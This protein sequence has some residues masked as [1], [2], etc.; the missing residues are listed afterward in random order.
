[1]RTQTIAAEQRS[2]DARGTDAASQRWWILAAC[3]VVGFAQLAEPQLWMIGFN[4]PASAFGTA[5]RGY[6]VFA[7]LGVVLFIA[8]Q[9]VGGVL[10]DL[11]GRRRVLL[12]GAAGATLSNALSLITWNIES[13]VATR[14]LVGVMGALAF[15]L[16]LAVVRLVFVGRERPLALLIYTFVTAVGTLASLLAIPIDDWFGWRWALLLPIASGAA[17]VALAWR[18]LPESRAA[19]GVRRVE[20]ITVAAWT[21]VLLALSFGLAVAQTSGTLINPITLASAAASGLGLAVIGYWR[22]GRPRRQGRQRRAWLPVLALS[23]L[24]YV[25]ATLTFALNGYVLQLYQ[26]FHTVQQYSVFVSGLAL[27]PIILVNAV[28]MRWAARFATERPKYLV[29]ALGLLAMSAGMLLTALMRPGLPYLLHIPGMALFGAGFLLAATAWTYFFFSALP[30]DLIGVSAGINRAAGLVGGALAG[31]V[32]STV[33]Q[34]SGMADFE[35]RLDELELPPAQQAQALDALEYALQ[36]G[37]PIDETTQAPETI[38][39]LAL[40]AAY[41]EAYSVG[42]GSAMVVGAAL[43]LAAAVI[44]WLWLTRATPATYQPVEQPALEEA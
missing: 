35:R 24:L 21:M 42:V 43:C 16:T 28:V 14:A 12:V 17:G 3:C 25:T 34:L 6:R 4:I 2:G 37:H 22:R 11:L 26:F 10:G 20:A 1:M 32:L 15:P 44:V 33:L 30:Q 19:G 27:A 31:V 40:L 7:N 5:W 29:I 38:V 8:F 41:R 36:L 39:K 23:L 9:L 18:Y 13:L